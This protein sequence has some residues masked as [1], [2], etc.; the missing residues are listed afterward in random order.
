MLPAMIHVKAQPTIKSGEGPIVLV[1]G[2]T[3]ELVQ[4]IQQVSEDFAREAG[5]H[6]AA[7]YGGAS[8]RD[9][10]RELYQKGRCAEVVVGCPGRM[11]DMLSEGR[12]NLKRCLLTLA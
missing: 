2:P 3:R 8:K 9:Q 11:L 6:C 7:L 1:L 5:M 10:S 4:Q 12:L